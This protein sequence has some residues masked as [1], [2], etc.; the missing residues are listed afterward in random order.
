MKILQHTSQ[1]KKADAEKVRIIISMCS[2]PQK[3]K[4]AKEK[5]RQALVIDTPLVRVLELVAL[6]RSRHWPELS[7]KLRSCFCPSSSYHWP[8]HNHRVM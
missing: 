4:G 7:A 6:L 1:Q 5:P 2:D 8:H 3:A